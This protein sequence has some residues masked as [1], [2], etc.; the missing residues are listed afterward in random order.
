MTLRDLLLLMHEHRA[1]RV[2]TTLYVEDRAAPTEIELAP[3]AFDWTGPQLPKPAEPE[4]ERCQCGH[5]IL[6]EH[7]EHG[8]LMG[9][10]L[11]SCGRAT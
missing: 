11:L 6:T 9:C 4:T 2:K 3:N 5:S 8:C 1:I 10:D 7:T